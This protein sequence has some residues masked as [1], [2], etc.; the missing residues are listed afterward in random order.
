MLADAD[1]SGMDLRGVNFCRAN[2][3]R[4]RLYGTNLSGANLSS[5]TMICPGLERTR[6]RRANLSGSYIHALAAQ[7]CDFVE[8]D[9]SGVLD[10]TGSLFHGCDLSEARL[11]GAVLSGATFYQSTLTNASLRHVV[12]QGSVFNECFLD[13]AQLSGGALDQ[14]AFTKCHMNGVR[15]DEA[16]G[17]GVV[18]QRPTGATE[19]VL[20]RAH[21][22]SLR[23]DSVASEG[24][25]AQ[26]LSAPDLDILRCRL[27]S[28]DFTGAD[29][30][31]GRIVSSTLDH[32]VLRRAL[33]D[34]AKIDRCSAREVVLEDG[35][36]ENLSAVES[37]FANG[38]MARFSGRCAS[39]RDCDLSGANFNGAYLYRCSMTGD[40]PRSMSLRGADFVGANL[41]QSYIA[42]DLSDVDLRNAQC[43]Y[44]RFNQ[45]DLSRADLRGTHLYEASLVKTTF[46]DASLSGLQPPFFADRCPGLNDAIAALPRDEGLELDRFVTELGQLLTSVGK[47]ST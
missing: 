41:V 12:L 1:F 35:L 29:L 11:D 28:A 10:A 34:G 30:R 21:F 15:L 31:R 32:A 24:L 43:A 7:V 17:E 22:P 38:Q 26:A 42:A 40:P 3:N 6:F 4:T 46:T 33:L 25:R 14:C 20:E 16:R 37:V 19:I 13:L 18:I 23:L 36:G 27:T 47:G 44:G 8:A 39:F 2:L 9:L 45:S 5:A